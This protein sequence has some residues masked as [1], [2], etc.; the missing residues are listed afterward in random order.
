VN[1]ADIIRA[2]TLSAAAFAHPEALPDLQALR[3]FGWKIEMEGT[4]RSGEVRFTFRKQH[5]AE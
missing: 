1:E 3:R 2:L 5:D 4:F